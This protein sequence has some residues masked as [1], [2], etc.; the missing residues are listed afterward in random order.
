LEYARGFRAKIRVKKKMLL[1][2]DPLGP[3][4]YG[5]EGA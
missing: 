1:E 4:F 3:N 2:I 5:A